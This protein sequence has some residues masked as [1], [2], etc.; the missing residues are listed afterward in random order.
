MV[1]LQMRIP[2]YKSLFLI[3]ILMKKLNTIQNLI[4]RCGA[5]LFVAGLALRLF[6]PFLGMI[7]F[8]VGIL[9]F[10]S[11]QLI[12][13]YEGNSLTIRRL[14]N[15][16]VLSDICFLLS[17]LAMTAQEFNFGPSWSH[18]NLWVLLLIIGCILQLYTSFRLPS[19]LEKEQAR[20][21][22]N[23][24][25]ALLLLPI[26]ITSCGTQYVV[27]G[28]TSV[29]MLEGKTLYLKAFDVDQVHN[30]DS[31]KVQHGRI[32]FNGALDSVQMVNVFMGDQSMM[33]LVLE[34]GVISLTIGET[35]QDVT[36][37]PLNDT[38][39]NFI[40]AKVKLDHEMAEL[41]R[42]ESRMIMEGVDEYER[43]NILFA[44]S[45]RIEAETDKLITSFIVRHS[46][47]VLGPGVFMIVTS[48][49]PFPQLTPQIEEILFRA[50]P[51]FKENPYVKRYVDAAKENMEKIQSGL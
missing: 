23:G 51:G 34:Q 32:R 46:D 21:R 35:Q 3:K 40:R 50:K 4:F 20:R 29:T 41:S 6:F 49:L 12:A 9:G 11:M 25:S 24:L 22:M 15:Q 7:L 38:L 43:N 19:E 42:R 17:A 37:S 39:Y 47:N 8:V 2:S 18:R 14:R 30:L 48:S 1:N 26:L 31:C 5:I 45:Q 16:Q 13:G 10:C 28:S 44:E 27:E 33:P 36:G